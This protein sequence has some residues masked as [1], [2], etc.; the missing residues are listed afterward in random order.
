MREK[1]SKKDTHDKG[2][3]PDWGS[4]AFD[5]FGKALLIANGDLREWIWFPKD[6]T[7]YK[8]SSSDHYEKG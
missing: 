6:T 2:L 4:S 7:F 1:R 3:I 5:K 8:I